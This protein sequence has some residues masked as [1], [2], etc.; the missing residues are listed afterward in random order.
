MV[1]A[2]HHAAPSGTSAATARTSRPT[3]RSDGPPP[4]R[5]GSRVC[6]V[7]IASMPATLPTADPADAI[8][9]NTH[10]RVISASVENPIPKISTN[11]TKIRDGTAI[12][13]ARAE[14]LPIN[15]S[16][17][18]AAPVCGRISDSSSTNTSTATTTA[19]AP[20]SISPASFFSTASNVAAQV[21]IVGRTAVGLTHQAP[22]PLVA[23]PGSG[24]PMRG[25][26]SPVVE[27]IGRC[28]HS[29]AS[30]ARVRRWVRSGPSAMRWCGAAVVIIVVT[31]SPGRT[32][33]RSPG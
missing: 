22:H 19:R 15:T 27:V 13:S 3:A 18:R 30:P 11:H 5:C 23:G 7:Q 24:A 29:C 17:P 10:R 12:D 2:P 33:T 14:S 4:G 9:A 16:T 8:H 28:P 6:R 1:R 26:P 25:R 32:P 21:V 31:T 20:G